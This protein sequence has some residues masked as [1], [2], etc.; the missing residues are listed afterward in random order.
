MV[1][2]AVTFVM[3][4]K[5]QLQLFFTQLYFLYRCFNFLLDKQFAKCK[6]FCKSVSVVYSE[7]EI[8]RSLVMRSVLRGLQNQRFF[9]YGE[10]ID[11]NFVFFKVKE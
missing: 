2:H 8:I 4:A 11:V 3:K 10:D 5:M 9:V 1:L 7:T 6:N